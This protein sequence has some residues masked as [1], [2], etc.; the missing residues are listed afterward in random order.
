LGDAALVEL[1]VEG[2]ENALFARVREREAPETGTEIGVN[3]DVNE[4]MFFQENQDPR[5]NIDTD[6]Q[7]DGSNNWLSDIQ[8]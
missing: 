6:H 5:E 7:K 1:A 4:V 8:P 2:V 3:L